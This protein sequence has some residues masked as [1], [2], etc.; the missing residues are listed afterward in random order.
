MKPSV[1]PQYRPTF[2]LAP[3]QGW[4]NDPV[5]F[6]H[7]QGAWHL[8][9][10]HHPHSPVWGP[11]HW[12]H[13]RSTDLV[14]WEHLPIALAPDSP[15]DRGG[16]FS[17]SALGMDDGSLLLMYTGVIPNPPGPAAQVQ[18]TAH[19]QDG[20]A[21]TKT[22]SNPVIPQDQI[23]LE[24][25]TVDFRDP[26]L[27]Y[28]EG[29]TY[30]LIGSQSPEGQGQVLLYRSTDLLHWEF[31]SILLQGTETQGTVWEC[32]DLFHLDGVDV[33]LV[34]PQ[35]MPPQGEA[36]RN[37]HSVVA[38]TGT[39]DWDTGTFTP[40]GTQPLDWG[41]DFYAPQTALAPDGRRIMIAWMDMWEQPYPTAQLGHGWAGAMT[42]PRELSLK[43]GRIVSQPIRELQAYRTMPQ[44]WNPFT[45]EGSLE[46]HQPPSSFHLVC[47]FQMKDTLPFGLILSTGIQEETR[48]SFTPETLTLELD[49]TPSGHGSG[50]S[51]RVI[52]ESLPE[53]LHLEIIADRSS[54]EMFV[55]HGEAVLSARIYPH[56]HRRT[57]RLWAQGNCVIM[58]MKLWNLEVR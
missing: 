7:W 17:G 56:Q 39:M 52:L 10:Q 23:P 16:C 48:L 51:R 49:R 43:N 8:F 28:R 19:S 40:L 9:Y 58:N 45:L 55:N 37:L 20:I 35:Y 6:I 30:A 33:L 15:W 41:F 47:E 50:G 24:A 53:T 54:L 57:L 3:P 4:M 13:A 25:S 34:S 46:I 26:R 32:P 11:M 21:F 38:F 1:N 14:Q 27:I 44:N 18:C 31:L 2:H 29:V 5:G 36:Y 22:P 42:L 12:G